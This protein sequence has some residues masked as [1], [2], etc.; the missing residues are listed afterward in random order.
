MSV[1]LDGLVPLLQVFD[2]PTSVRFYRDI[3]GFEIV[4]ASPER[5]PDD[6]D[7]VWLR[8]ENM[9]LMVRYNGSRE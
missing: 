1:K 6:S 2:M 9:E 3:L 4:Q 5:S 7:W 8:R